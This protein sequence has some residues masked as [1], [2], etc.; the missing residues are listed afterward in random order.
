[1]EILSDTIL[2]PS[3]DLNTTRDQEGGPTNVS[4]LIAILG[5]EAP[6]AQAPP[7]DLELQARGREVLLQKHVQGVL[8]Q[9]RA[10]QACLRVPA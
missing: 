6:H 8:P 7:R 9:I 1:M 3:P 5:Q 2:E 4:A 10:H